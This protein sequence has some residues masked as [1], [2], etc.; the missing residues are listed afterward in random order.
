MGAFAVVARDEKFASWDG[1]V[2]FA[3]SVFFGA[4]GVGLAPLCVVDEALWVFIV[5]DFHDAVFDGDAFAWKGNNTLDDILVANI[6][7]NAACH[8]VFD[9]FG[10]VFGNGFFVFIEKNNNLSAFWNVLVASEVS[11]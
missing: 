9:T 2:D 7:R 6:G 1:G 5:V 4:V 10:L 8:W 11:P 3:G